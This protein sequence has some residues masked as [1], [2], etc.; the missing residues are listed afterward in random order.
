MSG[1]GLATAATGNLFFVG[2]NGIFDVD[3]GGRDS[4][5]SL[6]QISQ[7]GT[8]PRL[9]TPHEQAAMNA[10]GLDLGSGGTLLLPDQ[11]GP[12]PHLALT[13]GK[14]ETIVWRLL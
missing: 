3:S 13:G 11:P 1:D 14:N 9:F 6:P 7:T 10:A 2:G 8:P 12:H 5:D 4:G